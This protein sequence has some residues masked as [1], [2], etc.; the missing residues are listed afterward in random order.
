MTEIYGIIYK[1]TNL[2]TGEIYIGQTTKTLDERIDEHFKKLKQRDQLFYDALRNYGAEN[3]NWTIID[4]AYNQDELDDKEKFW[5][6]YYHTYIRDE[7]CN[8]YN[9]TA[10][11]RGIGSG[12]YNPN[13]GRKLSLEHRRKIGKSLKGKKRIFTIEH[14][15]KLSESKKGRKLSE[16]HKEKLR[17]LLSG[18]KNPFYG[19]KHTEEARAKMSNAKKGEKAPQARAVVQLTSDG[20]FIAEYPTAKQ[21]AEAVNGDKSTIIKCCKGK[22]KHHKGY[23]WMYKE[24][25]LALK[26]V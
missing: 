9:M 8:G 14:R 2:I 18:S 23:K 15:K 16:E 10:G 24:D 4:F 17:A 22:K 3:F 13:F 19:K 11:G 1:A 25:Y 20:E 7:N 6:K 21:G 26:E 12:K 5:I